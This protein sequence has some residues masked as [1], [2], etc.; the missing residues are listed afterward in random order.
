[1]TGKSLLD[2]G[3]DPAH[4]TLGLIVFGFG[5]GLMIPGSD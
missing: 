1:M 4:V 3:D 5:Q 2:F